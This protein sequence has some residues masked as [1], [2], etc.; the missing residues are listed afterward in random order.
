MAAIDK[1]K[2]R[3]AAVNEDEDDDSDLDDVLA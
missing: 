3:Q 1:G 2:A